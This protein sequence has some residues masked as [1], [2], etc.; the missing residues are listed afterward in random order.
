[1]TSDVL[2]NDGYCFGCGP[3]NPIGLHLS[4]EWDG[5]KYSALW[6]PR[7][8]H[9]GWAG[10][11]HGG[12]LALVLDEALSRAALEKHGLS[13]VTAELSTRLKLPARV[14]EPLMV[15]AW[16]ETVRPRLIACAG[17][18]RTM[19]DNRLIATGQAKMMQAK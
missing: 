14:G 18:V 6:T 8:E 9:Q 1:M 15:T 10:R 11:V 5:D 13:W 4:F 16:I 12:L 2:E 7:R 3:Q 19:P 17:E